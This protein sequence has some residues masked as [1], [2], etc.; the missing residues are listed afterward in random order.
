MVVVIVPGFRFLPDDNL[1]PW[2]EVD[3]RCGLA[4]DDNIGVAGALIEMLALNR[5]GKRDNGAACCP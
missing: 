4:D 1:I 3:G 2:V 5:L